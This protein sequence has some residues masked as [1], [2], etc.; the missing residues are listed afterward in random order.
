MKRFSIFLSAFLLLASILIVGCKPDVKTPPTVATPEVP[1][2]KRT[3]PVPAFSG[4]SAYAHVAAQVAMGP[5]T[6]NSEGHRKIR[7]YIQSNLERYN[8]K[9]TVQEFPTKFYDGTRVKGYN[10]VGSFNPE[11]EKRIFL[12]AHYDT[13]PI[14]DSDLADPA[15][16]HDP[17][18]GADDGGSGVGAL[19]E[20]ARLLS[21]NPFTEM[22]VDL[23]FFDLE[24]NG[25]PVTK[26]EADMFSWALGSQYW[27]R[28]PHVNGYSP[29]FGVL[30][31]MVGAKDA[32]FGREQY[33]KQY[34]GDVQNRIWKLAK[35]MGKGE[36]FVDAPITGVTDDHYFINTIAG[37]PTVDIIYKPLDGNNGFGDHWH[38]HNDNLD[39][40]S[41]ETLGIVGQ[42]VTAT[43]Y[44]EAGNML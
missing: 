28:S 41:A 24:D 34:A 14:A 6:A 23:V 5:R 12:C 21:E 3:I 10:I 15:K 1:V 8:A 9:V 18:L 38:T 26:V 40:I 4:D 19:L 44:R 20:I 33:S 43:V 42:V 27:A 16:Y 2:V 32:V 31:D 36:R 22:G 13:R 37:W 7:A 39:I 25:N 30:L 29:K 11:A 17:I 35:K